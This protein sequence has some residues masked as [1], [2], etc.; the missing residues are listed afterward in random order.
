MAE[1]TEEEQMSVQKI[2]RIKK[3]KPRIKKIIS[4]RP[5]CRREILKSHGGHFINFYGR[6]A[7][8]SFRTVISDRHRIVV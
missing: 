2:V 5:W 1:P 3:Q 8:A 7:A 6:F 4:G